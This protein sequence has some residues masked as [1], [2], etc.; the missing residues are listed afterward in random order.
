MSRHGKMLKR[1]TVLFALMMVIALVALSAAQ[2]Q[3]DTT[4]PVVTS[5][6]P[7]DG[8]TVYTNG[9]ST[10]TK[11]TAT[12]A[13]EAGGSGVNPDSVMVHLDG[14]NML[15]DCPTQTESSVSCNATVTDLYPGVHPLDIYVADNAGNR[16]M[17]RSYLTVVVDDQ[18]PTYSNL[19]PVDGSI[20]Y[21]ST[22]TSTLMVGIDYS[23][24]APSSGN[25]KPMIHINDLHDGTSGAMIMGCT[26]VA[27]HYSCKLNQ[28]KRLRLGVNQVEVLMKD[29]VGN[30]NYSLPS[31]LNSYTVVDDVAPAVSGLAADATSISASYSDPAPAG[32]LSAS[33][34]SGIDT[35]TA[36]VKVDGNPVA[37]CTVLADGVSCPTPAGL[38]VGQ[39][40]ILVN[41]NDNAG[42]QGTATG[43]LTIDPPPCVSG[44]P[45][46]NLHRQSVGWASYA[47]YQA[48]E[49]SLQLSLTNDGAD[50]A[51]G[52]AI[53][54]ASS[55]G[56]VT[57]VTPVP[58]ALGSVAGGTAVSTTLRFHV[59]EGVGS[60]KVAFTANAMDACGIGYGYPQ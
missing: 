60:F 20:I 43:T 22:L 28:A 17:S 3:A 56:G 33:L 32:A 5:V 52:V 53:T 54:G 21:T 27:G 4:A 18:P 39:H 23:D 36:A 30:N 6:T 47:D 50:G 7:A 16:R 26:N 45:S 10:I 49:L 24:P 38:A 51:D 48:R 58:V 13:D 9:V 15:F 55:N 34:T 12:Y 14:G 2:A 29:G 1:T 41:V 42:N 11:I 37:G 25:I 46:L 31:R 57:L 40:D 8:S 19:L 59:P 35:A 44:K